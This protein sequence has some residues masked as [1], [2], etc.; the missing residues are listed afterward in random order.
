MHVQEAQGQV[1]GVDRHSRSMLAGYDPARLNAARVAV[2]GLGA[3]GQNVVQNL[4]LS[5]VG[6]LLL[7]D[8]DAFEERNA[9]RSPFFPTGD[10][11]ARLGLGKAPVVA[12]RAAVCAT[13]ADPSVRYAESLVQTAGDGVIRWADVVVSAVDSVSARAWLAER[14]RIHG[15]VMVEGGFA[16]AEFNLS[17]FLGTS[18]AV[19][20]RCLNPGRQS[21]GSCRAY[22]RTAESVSII[23]A[24][25]TSAA[26]LGG[27]MAEQVIQILIGN[28][29]WAGRTSPAPGAT[30]CAGSGPP[31]RPGW[32]V[33]S[34]RAVTARGRGPKRERRRRPCSCCPWTTR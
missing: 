2:V 12:N 26:V 34:A 28:Q 32:P 21:S 13:A 29:E 24:I 19:C 1:T 30:R 33:R 3:L 4:A 10:E 31:S 20:Y 7:V 5:G 18:G 16:A 9:T 17:A 8:Y 22:A 25:Q 6:N 14:S 11:V 15:R 27:M 23:P